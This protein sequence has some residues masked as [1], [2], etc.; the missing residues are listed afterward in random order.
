MAA[1]VS[2][3]GGESRANTSALLDLDED[4]AGP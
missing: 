4:L 2:S 3:V 1:I